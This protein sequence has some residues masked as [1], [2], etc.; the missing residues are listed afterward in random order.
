MV[1]RSEL[2]KFFFTQKF[3]GTEEATKQLLRLQAQF[4]L[5]IRKSVG[6]EETKVSQ[7]DVIW[8]FVKDADKT[9]NEQ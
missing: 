5:E 8:W 6:N 3:D 2:R 4:I 1:W 7:M 9:F